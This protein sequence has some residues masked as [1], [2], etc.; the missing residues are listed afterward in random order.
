MC[1]PGDGR[2]A[3]VGECRAG[4]K[5][6]PWQQTSKA[7][8]CRVCWVKAANSK[9]ECMWKITVIIIIII[10]IAVV[11]MLPRVNF[12][13]YVRKRWRRSAKWPV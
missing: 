12:G 9:A 11:G 8:V 4:A 13:E 6:L 10:I 2:G 5:R 3:N 7:E 1:C